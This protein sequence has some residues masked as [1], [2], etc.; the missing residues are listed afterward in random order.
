MKRSKLIYCL[1]TLLPLAP[2]APT[3][4]W[5]PEGPRAPGKPGAPAIPE[6]PYKA[7]RQSQHTYN[8]RL[9][10]EFLFKEISCDTHRRTLRSRGTIRSRG[11]LLLHTKKTTAKPKQL[12]MKTNLEIYFIFKLTAA[13]AGPEGPGLPASPRAPWGPSDPRPPWGP[14]SP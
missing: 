1:L 8:K 14:V 7:H 12:Y 9:W 10:I 3:A 2:G 4:P 13:P 6:G 11:T 5:P